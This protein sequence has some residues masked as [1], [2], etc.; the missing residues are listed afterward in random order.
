MPNVETGD[1]VDPG[2][3][4]EQG[5]PLIGFRLLEQVPVH[6]PLQVPLKR[7]VVFLLNQR[8]GFEEYVALKREV[9]G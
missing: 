4:V 5:H 8:L 2:G 9:G 3:V 6:R 7:A 1:D